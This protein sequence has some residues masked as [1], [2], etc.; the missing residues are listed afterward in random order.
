MNKRDLFFAGSLAG[1]LTLAGAALGQAACTAQQANTVVHDLS[2]AA[3]CIAGALAD[4]A[5]S[6]PMIIVAECAGVTIEDVITV[7]ADLLDNAPDAGSPAVSAHLKDMLAKAHT[8]K[9]AKVK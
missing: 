8:A 6:D 4:G 9:A 1:V 2:P 7:I 3:A 5:I